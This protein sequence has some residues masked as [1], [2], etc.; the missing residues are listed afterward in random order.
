MTMFFAKSGCLASLAL[1]QQDACKC[2]FPH[3]NLLITARQTAGTSSFPPI[4]RYCRV[5][6]LLGCQLTHL[7]TQ[8]CSPVTTDGT[9]PGTAASPSSQ[10]K[11]PN[12]S[13]QNIPPPTSIFHQKKKQQL[14]RCQ[15]APGGSPWIT[16]T[17]PWMYIGVPL[18]PLTGLGLLSSTTFSPA[19]ALAGNT[20]DNLLC[21]DVLELWEATDATKH[22]CT[23]MY[24]RR[25]IDL[26][27]QSHKTPSH[28]LPPE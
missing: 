10:W 2:T 13:A 21:R 22:L 3:G 9:D 6:W 19:R 25:S 18:L 11:F 5:F 16:S 1:I 8:A 20:N 4:K 26:F 17:S 7:D 14:Y 23:F 28:I 12:I 24:L 15:G 27:T